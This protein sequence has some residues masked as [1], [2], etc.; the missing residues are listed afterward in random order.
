MLAEYK[1]KLPDIFIKLDDLEARC[2]DPYQEVLRCSVI[3]PDL[4][5]FNPWSICLT[6]LTFLEGLSNA[7]AVHLPGGFQFLRLAGPLP[8]GQ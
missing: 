2:C 3:I 6:V 5:Q 4:F 7:F 8:H 1:G